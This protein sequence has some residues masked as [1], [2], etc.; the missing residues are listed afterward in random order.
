VADWQ[1]KWAVEHGITF[2][3]YD[4]Y[5]SRGARQLEHGLHDAFLK[6]RYRHLLKFCLL[7]ANHN[8]PRTSSHAD[9][10]AVTRYWIENYFRRPEHLMFDGKPVVIIFSTD[11]LTSD[12]GSAQVRRAFDAMRQECRSAGLEGLY[13]IACVAS[14]GQARLAAEEGYDAVTAYTWPGLGLASGET[15]GPY[16]TLIDGYRRQWQHLV[17]QA[18]LPLLVPICGGW[19]SRP[20]H[21]DD[22][23]VRHGRTPELFKGHLLDARALL[24]TNR[25]SPVAHAILIEAWNEWGEGSYIEP[26]KEFGFG[27]LEAIRE[28]FTS[29]PRDHTDLA[30]ADVGLG[31]YETPRETGFKTAWD[32]EGSDEGWGGTMQMI[33]VHAGDGRLT[34]RTSGDD[35]AFFGPPMQARASEFDAVVVRMRLQAAEGRPFNDSAQLF[36][37]TSRL[38]ESEATSIRFPVRGDGSWHEYRLPVAENRRWRGIVTR[39]RLDPCNRAD[40]RVELDAIRLSR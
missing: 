2:F 11:R 5:W 38:A 39:L 7:W 8:P 34:G 33:E 17:E 19:D 37:R 21:G 24:E 12:L 27:Y 15:R 10:L 29:A 26:H 4:W 14:A 40:A 18:P 30:P 31:P 6:A 23:L 25:P 3:A 35:P 9:C 28:V 32:F 20:W 22:N 16:D 1:I 36:W 13:L